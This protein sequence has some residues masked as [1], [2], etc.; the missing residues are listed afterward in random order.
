[1]HGWIQFCP[2]TPLFKEDIEVEIKP[3]SAKK[4]D[5][6]DNGSSQ[7]RGSVQGKVCVA[8]FSNIYVPI[9]FYGYL[10]VCG[11]TSPGFES[12]SEAGGGAGPS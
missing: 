11:A 6:I 9:G 7:R 10:E 5:A 1:M 8:L 2:P 4:R 12:L 3:I